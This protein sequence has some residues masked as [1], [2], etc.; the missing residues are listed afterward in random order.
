[1]SNHPLVTVGIPMYNASK[2]VRQSIVSVLQ[3]TY[4]NFEL[5]ITDDGSTDDSVRIA[6]EFNDPRI[7][8][9]SD[10]QNHGI[11]Y[12]LNQQ[13][14]LAKGKYFIRMDADDIM[15]PDRIER[16][17]KYLEEHPD[18]DAI[19]G[20][21]IIIGDSNEILGRRN[22]IAVKRLDFK[23]GNDS[24]IHPTVAGK[25]T[26]FRQFP[27]DEE[28]NGVEDQ[29]L[30]AQASQSCQ[31]IILPEIFMFYREPL[32]F[33]LKTYLFR[34]KQNR[35]MWRRSEFVKWYGV[36]RV[37]KTLIMSYIR[38]VL[39]TIICFAKHD[40]KMI[41]RRNTSPSIDDFK[42]QPFLN[43]MKSIK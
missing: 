15:L 18:T 27:Y 32:T 7:T 25:L 39:A 35:R 28:L 21:A 41:S 22:V 2:F 1:M 37:Y 29:Y 19:G 33:K 9:L 10:G 5:I 8:V 40:E 30:W 34:R 13:I 31:L 42:W 12:R 26:L 4:S 16:Q 24:F 23:T 11:S 3:Q 43:Q 38:G 20:G 14:Q 6:S 36:R 17:V